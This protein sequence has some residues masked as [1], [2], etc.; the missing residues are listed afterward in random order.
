MAMCRK[1][2][3]VESASNKYTM[4]K[5][6]FFLK[7]ILC[8]S[9]CDG[10]IA[11]EEIA[12]LKSIVSSIDIFKDIDVEQE[13]NQMIESLNE[14]GS[15]FLME[16]IDSIREMNLSEE[17]QLLVVK[18]AIDI[19]EADNEILY[20]EVKF[21]KKIRGMLSISDEKILEV[22]PEKEEYLLPDIHSSEFKFDSNIHFEKINFGIFVDKS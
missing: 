18:F 17:E 3:I 22:M 14:K 7:T 19:I 9:A 15:E 21:F 13:L 5:K 16:Y 8:C 12:T 2:H 1:I 20:S 10:E 6:Q 4:D 11:P